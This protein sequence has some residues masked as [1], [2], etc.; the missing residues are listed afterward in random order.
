M[1]EHVR[2]EVERTYQEG[3]SRGL[4]HEEALRA[5][6][7]LGSGIGAISQYANSAGIAVGLV[8]EIAVDNYTNYRNGTADDDCEINQSGT[9]NNE[10]ATCGPQLQ[11]PRQGYL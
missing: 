11:S 10:T 2:R 8:C 7:D 3:H 9:R 1:P 4:S 5:C 6:A